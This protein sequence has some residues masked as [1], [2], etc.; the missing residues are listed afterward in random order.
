ME[1]R[2]WRSNL[3]GCL[4]HEL[5]GE[6]EEMMRR[7]DLKF[8]KEALEELDPAMKGCEDEPGYRTAIVLLAALESGPNVEA[9]SRFTGYSPEFIREIAWRSVEAGLWTDDDVCCEH[10]FTDDGQVKGVAFWM[11]TLVA[12]GLFVRRWREEDG[13]YRYWSK[14]HAPQLWIS[15]GKTL[16]R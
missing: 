13:A 12:E 2:W 1:A 5:A 14:K 6:E 16:L 9:L 4:E 8:V 15:T 10:W 3:L 11:D 7:H